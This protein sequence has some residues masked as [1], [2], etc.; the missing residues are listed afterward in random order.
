MSC[1]CFASQWKK[2]VHFSCCGLCLL[3]LLPP[4]PMGE[5]HPEAPCSVSCSL[6][7]GLRYPKASETSPGTHFQATPTHSMHRQPFLWCLPSSWIHSSYLI[8]FPVKPS[9]GCT[10][11]CFG[12]LGVHVAPGLLQAKAVWRIDPPGLEA[13]CFSFSLFCAEEG[14]S[15]GVGAVASTFPISTPRDLPRWNAA[16]S[17]VSQEGQAAGDKRWQC[18]LQHTQPISPHR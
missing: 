13:L 15:D 17:G 9:V 5:S 10:A 12:N 8:Q 2:A 7:R 1:Q 4:V 11:H 16:V 3:D 6:C 18:H 14:C